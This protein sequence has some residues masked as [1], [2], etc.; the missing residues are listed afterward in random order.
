VNNRRLTTAAEEAACAKYRRARCDALERCYGAAFGCEPYDCPDEV[1]ADDTTRTPESVE[2][3]ADLF[4]AMTCG[5]PDP[6]C[7]TAGKRPAGAPCTANDQ[8]VSM[9]CSV[10]NEFVECGQCLKL[11]PKDG[12]CDGNSL[13]TDNQ[14]CVGTRCVDPKPIPELAPGTACGPGRMCKDG[15]CIRPPDGGAATCVSRALGEPCDIYCAG[16][17]ACSLE[18]RCEAIPTLG[19]PCLLARDVDNEVRGACT[20]VNVR[21]LD[22]QC[23]KVGMPG[24]P[25]EPRD[26]SGRQCYLGRCNCVG[27]DCSRYAC[28]ATRFAGESCADPYTYCEDP[29]KCVDGVCTSFRIGLPHLDGCLDG[30]P[31]P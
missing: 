4:D 9:R 13:C 2:A 1:F 18:G 17:A 20:G 26:E 24:D 25:C 31:S 27:D 3:C 19:E 16:E 10:S 11:V 14:Q 28:A 22:R 6:P 29:A 23:V 12:P 15:E 30:G 21:C 5:D 8:C 7:V